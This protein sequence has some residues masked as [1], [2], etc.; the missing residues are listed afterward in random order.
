MKIKKYVMSFFS[1][2]R[3]FINGDGGWYGLILTTL[4]ASHC[5]LVSLLLL[6]KPLLSDVAIALYTLYPIVL[7]LIIGIVKVK[8][9]N[10]SLKR[11]I[12]VTTNEK[13]VLEARLDELRRA[14]C[15]GGCKCED[16]AEE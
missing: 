14:S 10:K 1:K 4:I 5:V 13:L 11:S 15:C 9:K 7:S 12:K 8:K 16:E 6:K 2:V 3:G